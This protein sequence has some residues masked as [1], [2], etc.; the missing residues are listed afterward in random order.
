MDHHRQ[1]S[2]DHSRYI[3]ACSCPVASCI[4]SIL[5]ITT[6]YNINNE[7]SQLIIPYSTYLPITYIVGLVVYSTMYILFLL[8]STA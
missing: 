1:L 7:V 8:Y 5:V 2:V 4:V 3:I 6:S